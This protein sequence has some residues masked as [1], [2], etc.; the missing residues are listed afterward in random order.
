MK[1]LVTGA[2][3]LLGSAILKRIDSSEHEYIGLD[4]VQNG[5]ENIKIGS[6]TDKEF[7]N[8]HIQGCGAI[9]HTASVH[10]AQKETHSTAQFI[11]INVGGLSTLL[12]LCLEHQIK[13]FIFASSMEVIIGQDYLSNGMSVIK[14]SIPYSYDWAYPLTKHLCEITGKFY[15][16]KHGVEFIS[17]RYM[18]IDPDDPSPRTRLIARSNTAS[19]LAELNLLAATQ[20]KVTPGNYN[21]GPETPLTN[22]DILLSQNSVEEVFEKYWPGSYKLLKKNDVKIK[23]NIFWPVVDISKVC[24][25]FS[26]KPKTNFNT[27]LN[28]LS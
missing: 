5:N 9:I 27:Y 26:W 23:N 7:L 1:I 25:E 21:V 13:R 24:K 12:D 3:G 8:Q 20:A 14:D 28:S 11:D 15:Q 18:N 2:A 6:F 10:G 19:D 16:E 22:Q 17:L 4:L